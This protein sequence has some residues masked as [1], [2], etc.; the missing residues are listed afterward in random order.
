MLL[1]QIPIPAP[2]STESWLWSL[3]AVAAIAL[4]L[5][6]LFVRQPPIEAEFMLRRSFEEHAKE[7]TEKWDGIKVEIKRDI[8]D[9]EEKWDARIGEL[10]RTL[11]EDRNTLDAASEARSEKVL[12]RIAHLHEALGKLEGRVN[13]TTSASAPLD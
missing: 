5:K 7:T 11:R 4:L 6:K 3:A 1:A 12:A 9:L 10:W 13:R 8:K 2:G